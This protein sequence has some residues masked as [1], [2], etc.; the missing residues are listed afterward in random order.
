MI[1]TIGPLLALAI[2]LVVGIVGGRLARLISLPGVTG[3]ILAGVLIGHSGLELFAG[4]V[5][6]DIG[7]VTDFALAF[8]AAAVGAHLCVLRLRN[9]GKRLFFLLVTEATL[10][11]A[12]TL[13]AVVYVGGAPWDLGLL[14]AAMAVSTA[15]ATILALAL[16]TRSKGV[17][18]KTLIAAVAF[19]NV[20]CIVL[21]EVVRSFL[22]PAGAHAS[23]QASVMNPFL[24]LLVAV[25]IGAAGGFALFAATARLSQRKRTGAKSLAALMGVAGLCTALN[26]SSMLGCLALGATLV[27]LA[28]NRDNLGA[29]AFP[30]LEP[31][32]FAVFFTL[33]GMHL[34]FAFLLPAIGLVL[35]ALVGRFA[36]KLVAANFAMRLADAPERVRRFLGMGLIPQAGVAVGLILVITGDPAFAPLHDTLLAIGLSTVIVNELVGPVLTR[37]ALVKSGDAGK[38]RARVIDFIQEENIEV[39]LK[40]KTKEEAILHLSKLLVRSNRLKHDAEE[41]AERALKR[42][43]EASTCVGS[44]L[45]VPHFT[46]DGPDRI[47]GAIGISREG[48]DF[49][50]PDEMPVHCMVLLGTTES[51]CDRHL[52]VLAALARAVSTSHQNLGTQL[53]TAKSPAHVYQLLHAEDAEDF[54]YFLDAEGS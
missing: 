30:G 42:E 45:A 49:D 47:V 3:Q 20:A 6:H 38:D 46:L 19:N 11:P 43:M 41:L 25:A 9:A 52:E 27:N 40:A 51:L 14:L 37:Q 53:F 10:T 35:A 5:L 18:V 8:I 7:I 34:D 22:R 32:I 24:A 4:N 21:F 48:L 44:G 15:P 31:A 33:A 1:T 54:N 23:A 12:I 50:T 36:G 28:P 13:L 2:V 29:A 39:D 16:E 26:V 17:F